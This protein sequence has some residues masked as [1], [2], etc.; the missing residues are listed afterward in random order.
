M[1]YKLFLDDTRE[2]P[3]LDWEVVRSFEQ[4]KNIITSN[5]LPLLVSFDYDLTTDFSDKRTKTGLACAVWMQEFIVQRNLR[6]PDFRVHSQNHS[7]AKKIR[8]SMNSFINYW[9]R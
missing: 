1:A 4:F 7:G 8:D 6:C 9:N 3:S 5:G 2:P